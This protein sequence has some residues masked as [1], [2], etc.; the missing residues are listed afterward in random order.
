MLYARLGRHGD[1]LADYKLVYD[2]KQTN[3]PKVAAEKINLASLEDFRKQEQANFGFFIATAYAAESEPDGALNRRIGSEEDS[4]RYLTLLKIEHLR[5]LV[6]LHFRHGVTLTELRSMFENALTVP[7]V[8]DWLK[9]LKDNFLE[10]GEVP[11]RV[12][13]E[14]LEQEKIDPLAT[15]NIIAVRAKQP[16]LQNFEPERLIARLKAVE[17]IVGNRWI[18]VEN[19]G[20]VLMYQTAHQIL[21]KFERNIDD[22]D[23]A[24]DMSETTR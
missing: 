23:S 3:S 21:E 8:N 11:L 17:N 18:E 6:W 1:T 22:L 4:Y 10:Q 7:Q 20:N 2:A 13:L 19:S 5:C 24:T 9:S 14:G 12:L 16:N 15:P